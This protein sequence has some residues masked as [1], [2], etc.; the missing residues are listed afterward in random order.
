MQLIPYDISYFSYTGDTL[1]SLDNIKSVNIE[2]F[3]EAKTTQARLVL[4]I[5]PSNIHEIRL[6]IA[7]SLT[8]VITAGG[9][10]MVT[11]VDTQ[12]YV[13]TE[14]VKKVRYLNT[15]YQDLEFTRIEVE[16]GA[17]ESKKAIAVAYLGLF[18]QGETLKRKAESPPSHPLPTSRPKLTTPPHPQAPY[19]RP[20]PPQVPAECSYSSLLRDCQVFSLDERYDH[21][22]KLCACLG[23]GVV[24]QV[25][26]ATHVILTNELCEVMRETKMNSKAKFVTADWLEG[27]LRDRKRKSEEDF[28][29]YEDS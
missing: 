23:A 26:D 6:G 16:F 21:I 3:W 11:L 29:L 2:S 14:E 28:A 12:E 4:N 5:P 8:V 7:V 20:Q 24:E 25:T 27:C 13:T 9:D 15:N 10:D 18:R 22:K 1:S 19:P 17:V